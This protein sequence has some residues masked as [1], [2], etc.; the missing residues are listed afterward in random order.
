VSSNFE[1]EKISIKIRD[2]GE[3]I[4]SEQISHLFD[5]FYRVDTSRTRDT[6]GT[7]LGLAIVKALVEIHDGKVYVESTGQNK[8]S[9][10]TV[11]LPIHPENK[12]TY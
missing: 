9:T 3:G 10:F 6:G 7:G 1:E 2:T 12:A 8:G 5:R 4:S 11:I